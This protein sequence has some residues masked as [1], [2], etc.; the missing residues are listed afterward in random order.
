MG[1]PCDGCS[2]KPECDFCP[3]SETKISARFIPCASFA[4]DKDSGK[5]TEKRQEHKKGGLDE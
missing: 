3:V 1:H 2:Q 5:E 4:R